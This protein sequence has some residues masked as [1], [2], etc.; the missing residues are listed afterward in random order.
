MRG[1]TPSKCRRDPPDPRLNK[2]LFFVMAGNSR[3]GRRQVPGSASITV[4]WPY[5]V[6]PQLGERRVDPAQVDQVGDVDDR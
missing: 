4:P 1:G 2:A 3:H 5:P 6:R